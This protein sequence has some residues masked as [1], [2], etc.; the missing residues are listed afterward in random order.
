MLKTS[1]LFGGRLGG[2]H[3]QIFPTASPTAPAAHPRSQE[4]LALDAA[5]EVQL[6]T[7]AISTLPPPSQQ[8]P[9]S[10]PAATSPITHHHQPSREH[11]LLRRGLGGAPDTFLQSPF[12][13]RRAGVP[14]RQLHPARLWNP[15][16]STPRNLEPPTTRPR[17][18]S[19]P[20]P[21]PVPLARPTLDV[22]EYAPEA[23]GTSAG[24]YPLLTV[25]EQREVRSALSN[26][27]SLHLDRVAGAEQRASLPPS[28][29]H[30]YD[31]KRASHTPSPVEEPEAGPSTNRHA[32]HLVVPEVRKYRGRGL[33][34]TKLQAPI[35]L[36]FRPG[37]KQKEDKG[38]GK[39]VMAP[40]EDAGDGFTPDLERGPDVMNHRHSTASGI[41]GIG[42][43][44]SSSDSS[45]MG[46]PD[47]P[48]DNGEEWGPQHPCYPHL[49]PHVPTDSPEY[50]NTRIIR[51]RRDWLLEGDLAPTFSN[52]YPDILDPAGV[53]EQEF[54]RIID[55][56]NGELVPIFSP[57]AWRNILDN[58]L[59]L[60]TGWLWDDL[61]FTAA[62][63]RLR[64]LEE[65]IEQWNSDMEKGMDSEEGMIPPKIVPLRRTGY[66]TV[67]LINH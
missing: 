65:W 41:S 27:A 11:H 18:L 9:N 39:E 16:N 1:P 24:D 51:V 6:P 66:M 61:G 55:K 22:T 43:A 17:R 52:L 29:R 48:P 44:I 36:S 7:A 37:S 54:R 19:T 3:C 33:S 58:V 8:P 10:P 12:R 26:R 63:A 50:A 45:I 30:S 32:A 2:R 15:T 13:T 64:K 47:Q 56:L 14:L 25:P 5:T 20:P 53:S 38:K 34:F 40:P 28:L 67:C 23:P 57:Y 21:P 60:A 62:K 49:N 59:G 4:A 42:S 46:D 35:G 31:G